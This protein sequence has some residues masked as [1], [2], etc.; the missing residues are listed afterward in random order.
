MKTPDST[1]TLPYTANNLDI[2]LKQYSVEKRE[3]RDT[4]IGEHNEINSISWKSL[5]GQLETAYFLLEL[6]LTIPN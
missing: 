1:I 3:P 5:A 2:V 4:P 6:R